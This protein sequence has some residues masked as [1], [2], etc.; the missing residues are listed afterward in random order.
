MTIERTFDLL[1]N[2]RNNHNR[3]DILAAKR[4]GQ[5]VKF[6]AE[7]YSRTSKRFSYGLLASG[8]KKG[9]KIATVSN[10]RPEWN[11]ADMGMAMIGAIHVPIYPT[12]GDDEYKHILEHSDTRMLIVS[13]KALY[14]RLK[15]IADTIPGIEKVYTFNYYEDA[16]HWSEITNL[17]E[18][19][20]VT[21]KDV[22][23]K[24]RNEITPD[25]I[26]SIIYTSG[27]TGLPKGVMLTHRNFISNVKACAGLFGIKPG[28]RIL[29]FLPICHVFERM[30]NYLFQFNGCSI[31]Y[32][33]NLGTIAQNMV[34][35]QANAFATVPR[36]IERIYDRIVSKGGDLKG[37]KRLIF[38][39]SLKLGEKF[40]V[41]GKHHFWYG[42]RLW[43]ARKLVF[44]KW[45]KAFGGELRL[46]V[47]GGAALQPRLSRLFFAAGI[48][49]L[50]GYGLTET[51]PV[52][53]VNHLSRPNS[54]MIGTVGPIIDGVEVKIDEDGEILV[55]GDNIMKGYY[56]DPETTA[57]VVDNQGWF[58]TGDIGT[59]LNNRFLKI[60]DRKKEMFKTSSGKY[61]APQA[62]ENMLKES[63][64]IEQVMV[65]GEN[66]KFA[67]ALVLPNFE[68]LHVW[69]N[70]HR[71]HFRD[72]M[73]L[74]SIPK[75]QQRF[76]KEM[77]HYNKQLGKYEQIKRFRLVYEAWTAQTGELS[78][79]LKL[80]RRVLYKK[81]A[82]ILRE[83][84]SYAEGE[85]NRGKH[86]FND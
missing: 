62:I 23:L 80:K 17:G 66:E 7:D 50:E 54:L 70:N 58:H 10:N 55:K 27:T 35:I 65:V 77:D 11:M 53:A 4:E 26:A 57:S 13:D 19:N 1:E 8:F 76:Q 37:V 86:K 31:Y 74:I 69:A 73:E 16:P 33:E 29:S 28:D 81:Y 40:R 9:D 56:K 5:W 12:I 14:S 79:T 61:I 71:I 78:P 59:L 75:V 24:L 41:D 32:A 45:Q 46:V 63:N 22:L 68:Y 60:T 25:D 38:F 67:S 15:P 52:I 20:R 36:V 6:S 30:V 84:Y 43:L 42:L 85:E 44:S 21:Y 64:F 18:Q 39:Q 49:L 47:S 48:P 83:I 72:N 3:E 34:E 2:L 82:N 51:S